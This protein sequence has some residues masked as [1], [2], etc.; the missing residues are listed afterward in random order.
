MKRRF[1]EGYMGG[2]G[3]TLV[4]KKKQIKKYKICMTAPSITAVVRSQKIRSLGHVGLSIKE[5][6]EWGA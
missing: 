6:A 1:Y 3:Q 5:N 4:G 2:N